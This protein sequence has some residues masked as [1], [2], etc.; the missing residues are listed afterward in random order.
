MTADQ[1]K[2]LLW[3]N[4]KTTTVEEVRTEDFL[5]FHLFNTVLNFTVMVLIALGTIETRQT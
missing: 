4:K 2:K 1:K 3:G 5:P